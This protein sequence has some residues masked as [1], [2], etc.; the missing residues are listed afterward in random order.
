MN[1]IS[2]NWRDANIVNG[3]N[4]WPVL[5]NGIPCSDAAGEIIALGNGV[6]NGGL[7]VGD[8][9]TPILDQAS[10][11]GREQERSWLAADIDGVLADYLVI[12]Q[13]SGCQS[14]TL[15]L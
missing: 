3:Q 11:T 1:A 6:G 8:T 4:P 10:I 5:P 15:S 14:T 12:D 2:L 9:V 13:S 7:K